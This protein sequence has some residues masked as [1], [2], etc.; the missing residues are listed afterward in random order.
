MEDA[1]SEVQIEEALRALQTLLIRNHPV[2]TV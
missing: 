1:L 2:T